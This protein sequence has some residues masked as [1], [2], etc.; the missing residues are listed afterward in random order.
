MKT[1]VKKIKFYHA[2]EVFLFVIIIL[3][4]LWSCGSNEEEDSGLDDAPAADTLNAPIIQTP[5]PLIHLADNLDEQDQLGW[6]ID[7][8]G[9][10]FN[11]DL[12]A[13]SCKPNGG[14]VQFF[15][16]EVTLQICSVEYT[17]FCV[18]MTGGAVAGMSLNLVESNTNSVDQRFVYNE[19]S[20]EFNPE[21]AIDL[22]L[23][24][25][26]T[27]AEAGI[28]MSRSLTLE[29]SSETDKS[30]KKWVIVSN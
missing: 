10:G 8:R 17:G 15:Y 7:T 5:S 28:Y 13:H 30:L 1:N 3:T 6:C 21:A 14:D 24:A 29:R 16:D 27:S 23:S 18:E 20:G 19:D 25:G 22:C 9:N 2:K 26:D 4:F 11:E 12:H